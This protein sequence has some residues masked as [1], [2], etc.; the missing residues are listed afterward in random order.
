M[1][2]IIKS[3]LVLLFIWMAIT[4]II[5]RFKCQKLTETELFIRIP[6]SFILDWNECKK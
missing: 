5:Q 1:K 4:T 6:N 2:K 3:I